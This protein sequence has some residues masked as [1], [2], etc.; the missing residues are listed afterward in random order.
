MKEPKTLQDWWNNGTGTRLRAPNGKLVPVEYLPG[1][2]QETWDAA[3]ESRKDIEEAL[4]KD[5]DNYKMKWDLTDA[6][7][8]KYH[9]EKSRLQSEMD[10]MDNLLNDVISKC[11]ESNNT[12]GILKLIFDERPDLKELTQG[13]KDER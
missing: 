11:L 2:I 1:Y 7:S 8:T 13:S 12:V 9:A 4:I 5:R 3:I 10:R 6:L